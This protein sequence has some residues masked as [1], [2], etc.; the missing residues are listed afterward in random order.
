MNFWFSLVD[1]LCSRFNSVVADVE[2]W[3]Q[4]SQAYSAS[5][6][7]KFI[8]NFSGKLIKG[9]ILF[10]IIGVKYINKFQFNEFCNYLNTVPFRKPATRKALL[11]HDYGKYE[12]VKYK[13]SLLLKAR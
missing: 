6:Q 3:H 9:D 2:D 7:I 8:T 1:I 4:L 10:A 12:N 13:L 11:V 5:M